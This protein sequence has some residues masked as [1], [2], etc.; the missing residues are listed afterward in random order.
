VKIFRVDNPHTKPVAFWSWVIREVQAKHPEVIFL[1]EAFTRPKMMKALSKAG[2]T[3]SY[4]YFMWRSSKHELIE[5]MTELSQT[6]MRTYFRPNFFT[7][8]P[9]VLPNFFQHG[10]RPAFKLRLALAA[11]L[12]PSY[13]IIS[14]YELCENKALPGT[15]EY[16]DSEKYE[17]RVRNWNQTGNI[18]D[19]VAKMNAIRRENPAFHHLENL[20]FVKADNDNVIA[21]LKTSHDRSNMIVTAVN[22]DPHN[23]QE[24]KLHLPMDAMGFSW[25]ARFGVEELI[26]GAHLEW[27]EHAVLRLDPQDE[28]ARIFRVKR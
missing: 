12:S 22:L 26:G 21:Y 16:A 10:G 13:G 18:N 28:P 3:Q 6:D 14:G 8:T 25:G 1:G 27:G 23:V 2:F 19:F 11:T 17:I 24:T 5:Y 9:D 20:Q 4:T 15:E 7:T